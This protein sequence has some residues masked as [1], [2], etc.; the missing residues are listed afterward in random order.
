VQV[1]A[2]VLQLL[3]LIVSG[4]GFFSGV[5]GGNIRLELALL[6]VGAAVFFLG[7]LIQKSAK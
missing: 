7:R 2:R 3:G 5:I 4:A 6:G 1:A